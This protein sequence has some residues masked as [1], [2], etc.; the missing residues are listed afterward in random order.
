MRSQRRWLNS[1]RRCEHDGEHEGFLDCEA[2]QKVLF[3]APAR[4][5]Y[6]TVSTKPITEPVELPAPFDFALEDFV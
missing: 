6:Q 2:V 1:L 4:G 3:S 5:D